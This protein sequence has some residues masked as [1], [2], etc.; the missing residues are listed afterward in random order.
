MVAITRPRVSSSN[1]SGERPAAEPARSTLAT[2]GSLTMV[3]P[4]SMPYP[5]PWGIGG[6]APLQ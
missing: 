3:L 1:A 4:A 2:C 6:R 5:R